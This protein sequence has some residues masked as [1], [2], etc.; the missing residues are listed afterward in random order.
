MS[1]P[2]ALRPTPAC[3]VC[4]GTQREL[5]PDGQGLFKT[6][7]GLH[8]LKHAAR[9]L[10]LETG[11]LVAQAK[12]Y[13]CATCRTGYL[14]PWLSSQ[15]A[16]YVF[17]E[18]TPDHIAG[19]AMFEQWL[20]S[21]R[22]NDVQELSGRLWDL[23]AKRGPVGS[24]AEFGCPFQGFLLH[25]VGAETRPS[26]RIGAFSAA[27]RREPDARWTASARIHHAASRAANALVVAYHRLR[28]LRDS[29]RGGAPA[30]APGPFPKRRYLL[31]QDT[32][33]AWSNN[34]VRYGGS[35]RYFSARVL[36]AASIPFWGD[37]MEPAS[38]D[39]IGIFN[40]LDHVDDPV[41]VLRRALVLSRRVVVRT[42]HAAMAGK[43]HQYAFDES[44]PAWLA[45]A[46]PEAAVEDLTAEM[47]GSGRRDDNY[48]LLSRRHD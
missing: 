7:T 28:A 14:D 18:A 11:D 42:H 36:D 39:L 27:M 4:R 5:V 22:P 19:W 10:G 43:Q 26:E 16:S 24:Y 25:F 9:R 31:T 44:F 34:C 45:A 38:L 15:T 40:A 2:A 17:T 47:L 37:A 48:L 3:P 29:W 1:A 30:P 32:I 21:T 41:A 20:G 23:V 33:R 13:R 8:Y 6:D 35:C 12:V 46:L